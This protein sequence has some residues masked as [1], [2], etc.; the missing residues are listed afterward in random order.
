MLVRPGDPFD[1]ARID[2]SLKTLYA[3][4][5]F[6]DVDLTRQGD[7]LVVKVVENPLVNRVAFEG[8][9]LESDDQLK[10]VV[11]LRPR[12]VFTPAAAEA[13]RQRILDAYAKR[14]RFAT[15][16]TPQIIRLSEN[17]VDV[18]FQIAD[19]PSAFIAHIGFVGNH[20]FSEGRLDDVI[21]TRQHTWWRF[22][23]TADE[24]D[25]AR[26]NFDKELLRRFYLKNGYADFEVTELD[27]RTVARSVGVVPD[28]Q[29][30][31]GRAL[32]G[33]EDHHQLAT[34]WPGWRV[35]AQGP[36][37]STRATGTTATRSGARRTRSTRTCDARGYSFVEVKPDVTRH[38]DKHIIDLAFNVDEGPRGVCRAHR[39][40]RQRAHQGQGHPP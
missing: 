37:A 21:N 3:T 34:A 7:T 11:Q 25:P 31:R 32:P 1:P 18:V 22:L 39:H 13:D 36:A 33:R 28:L 27:D 23:S 26:I 15:V 20:A 4:G 30:E 29:P 17:R 14:G 24:Y 16:V 10:D 40:R 9:H 2:R 5:L 6:Q 8:N 35:A 12:A 19:G 38:T